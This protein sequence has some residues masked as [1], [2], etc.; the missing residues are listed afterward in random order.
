MRMGVKLSSTGNFTTNQTQSREKALHAFC[1]LTSIIDLKRL[2][3]KHANKLFETLIVPILSYGCEV[4]GAYLKQTFQTWEKSPIEKVHLRFCK[5]YLGVNGKATNIACRAELGGFALKLLI[6]LRILKYFIRLTDLPEDS[7]AKQAFM[8]SKSLF[9]A[10]KSSFHTN[11]HHILELYNIDRP[12]NQELL[13]ID[14]S[15]NSYLKIMKAENLKILKSKLISSRKFNLCQPF[16]TNYNEEPYLMAIHNVEQRIQYT[17]FRI[18]NHNLATEEGRYGKEKVPIENR[19]CTF[20]NNSEIETEKHMLFKC[21]HYAEIRSE[22]LAKLTT[23]KDVKTEN[24]NEFLH[25][26]MT[27]HDHRLIRLVSKFILR[28]FQLRN[29]ED[30]T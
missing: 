28:C 23:V 21:A 7:L 2:K 10:H 4:W 9:D 29:A 12:N 3:P 19:L 22:F 30:V 26:L 11:L 24:E 27:I 13:V 1:N 14:T 20:C 5:Y 18:S 16:K 17:K 15:C 8:M 25:L 6:D